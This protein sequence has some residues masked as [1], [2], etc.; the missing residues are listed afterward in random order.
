MSTK[1]KV[2]W[3]RKSLV[4]RSTLPK[5]KESLFIEPNDYCTIRYLGNV[6]SLKSTRGLHYLAILLH[7]PG[8]EFHVSELL[9]HPAD[10]PTPAGGVAAPERVK[11][12]LFSGF[13]VLDAQAKSEYKH[14]INELRQELEEAERCSDAQRKIEIQN[15]LQAICDNLA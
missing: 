8:R 15:E 3:V 7:H 5:Q 9:A 2:E 6:A 4:N 1:R 14:R 13:P 10:A 11:G 12:G